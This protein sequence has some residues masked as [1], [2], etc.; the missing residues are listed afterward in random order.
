MGKSVTS[1]KPLFNLLRFEVRLNE[2][3]CLLG[4]DLLPTFQR[5]LHPEVSSNSEFVDLQSSSSCVLRRWS[6]LSPES[7]SCKDLSRSFSVWSWNKV[8]A[9]ATAM[10]PPKYE[11]SLLVRHDLCMAHYSFLIQFS[12]L[13]GRGRLP[14]FSVA[15]LYP[16]STPCSFHFVLL[17]LHSRQLN[18]LFSIPYLSSYLL[19]HFFLFFFCLRWYSLLFVPF[20]IPVS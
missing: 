11:H 8:C 10:S 20:Q 16:L 7:R 17:C 14:S 2:A 12:S 4:F 6:G 1:L 9:Q 3:G 18:T 15:T 5:Y 19:K 13:F